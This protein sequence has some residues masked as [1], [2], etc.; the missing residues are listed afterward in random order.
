[1]GSV[2]LS[3]LQDTKYSLLTCKEIMIHFHLNQFYSVCIITADSCKIH[4]ILS[5]SSLQYG[6]VV[7]GLAGTGHPCLGAHSG[8]RGPAAYAAAVLTEGMRIHVDLLYCNTNRC[9]WDKVQ[10]KLMTDVTEFQGN[11]VNMRLRTGWNRIAWEKNRN[12]NHR[13][14]KVRMCVNVDEWAEVELNEWMCKGGP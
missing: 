10:C 3:Q 4:M 12:V 14:Q 2:S 8:S 9:S 6:C 7:L 11:K 1:M 13:S 5:S